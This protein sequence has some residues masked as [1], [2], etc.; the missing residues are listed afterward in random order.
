MCS[1]Q[2]EQCGWEEATIAVPACQLERKI[3]YKTIEHRDDVYNIYSPRY[4][5]Y[6]EYPN[7]TYCVWN[8]ADTGLVSYQIIDQQLQEP[9]DC[10]DTGCSCPD[11]VKISMGTNEITLCGN[12]T[13]MQPQLSSNGLNVKFCSDNKHTAKGIHL[14]VT[15][16]LNV[17]QTSIVDVTNVQKRE[18]TLAQ[19]ID[20]IVI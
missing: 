3:N 15:R 8:I 1:P 9:L 2:K 5:S 11:S 17:E 12:E 20:P 18:A 13:L 19:V 16:H 10:N 14:V 6:N 7:N 4:N